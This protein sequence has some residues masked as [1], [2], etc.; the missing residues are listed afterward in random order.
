MGW[1]VLSLV[2]I[3][4]RISDT[5]GIYIVHMTVKFKYDSSQVKIN[6]ICHYLFLES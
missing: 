4:T 1:R 2:E 6:Q 5:P 3:S